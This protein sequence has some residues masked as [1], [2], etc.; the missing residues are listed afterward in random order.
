MSRGDLLKELEK[1]GYF[2]MRNPAGKGWL[3]PDAP[4]FPTH[5][6][7]VEQA[8]ELLPDCLN[9]MIEAEDHESEPDCV[10]EIM[11]ATGAIRFNLG[12]NI[13]ADAEDANFVASRE[14]EPTP[15]QVAEMR[16]ACNRR[17]RPGGCW[18]HIMDCPEFLEAEP[19]DVRT[20]D[21]FLAWHRRC[22]V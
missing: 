15:T 4:V 17:Y 19:R 20:V 8:L 1:G 22:R 13:Y 5:E 11:R 10:A 21:E 9:R 16:K 7:H 6:T 2:D 3:L 12:E 14:W 18:F